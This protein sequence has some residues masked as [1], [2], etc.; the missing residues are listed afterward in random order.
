MSHRPT[1]LASTYVKLESL[2]NLA[3]N[4]S[5]FIPSYKKCGG[6]CL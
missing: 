4:I 6:I 5:S 3:H 2:P 1:H